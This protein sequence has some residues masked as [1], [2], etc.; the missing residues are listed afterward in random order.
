[1]FHKN[2][3]FP[4]YRIRNELPLR[5]STFATFENT[6]AVRYFLNM[7]YNGSN[8]HGWQTQ[9][10]A[11]TVQEELEKCLTKILR[12]PTAV[13][14]AGRTDT[15]VH[16]RQMYAHF[17]APEIP[18]KKR[19][20]QSLNFMMGKEVA[21]YDILPVQAKAHARFD[22]LQRQYCYYLHRRKDPF[23]QQLS[24]H[25]YGAMDIDAM[26]KAAG[27]LLRYEDFSSFCKSH[28]QSHTN[29]CTITEA[30]WRE[31]GHQLI[32]TVSANR[33]LRNMVRALVGT[34]LEVGQ[35]KIEVARFKE[36]IELKNRSLAGQSA[37]AHGLYLEKITYPKEIFNG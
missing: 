21:I 28:A 14:G 4:Y 36:I 34:L 9:P 17:D 35:G 11:R 30:H 18:D 27:E 23:L 16:A 1:M 7:A 31:Q 25:F 3:K 29:L 19:F 22:A 8:F 5:C 24:L 10:N 12:Q 2:G 13:T 20:L 33:F 32:F 15:G 37:P 6:E 26:N